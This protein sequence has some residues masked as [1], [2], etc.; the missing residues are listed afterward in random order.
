MSW[1][2]VVGIVATIVVGLPAAVRLT[3][4]R[5][6]RRIRF[7]PPRVEVASEPPAN[8][9]ELL[10]LFDRW[11]A[12]F[13]S[14]GFVV[15]AWLQMEDPGYVGLPPLHALALVRLER[16]DIWVVLKQADVPVACRPAQ[17]EVHSQRS[18]GT[19][20]LTTPG[21]G[22]GFFPACPDHLELRDAL[23]DGSHQL[24]QVHE[25]ALKDSGQVF[26]A[27][28]FAAAL[29][30]RGERDLTA[31]IESGVLHRT[32]ETDR[33]R[34]NFLAAWR[35]AKRL[36][37][38]AVHFWQHAKAKWSDAPAPPIKTQLVALQR[39]DVVF[40]P[41]PETVPTL[42]A[43]LLTGI[44]ALISFALIW[45]WQ[46]AGAIGIALLVHELGHLLA[47]R[48]FGYRDLQVFF[49][50]FMGG[51]TTG[52]KRGVS[53]PQEMLVLLAGPLPGLILGLVLLAMAADGS[54]F[55]NV[56]AA[57]LIALNLVNLLPL[58]PLDGGRIIHLLLARRSRFIETALRLVAIAC[59]AVGGFL[60]GDPLLLVL[61]FAVAAGL[62]TGFRLQRLAASAR[63]IDIPEA[64]CGADEASYRALAAVRQE[65]KAQDAPAVIA[66]TLKLRNRIETKPTTSGFVALG[67]ALYILSLTGGLVA[68]VLALMA[69]IQ[70]AE[71]PSDRLLATAELTPLDCH[72]AAAV[73][74]PAT[75]YEC[76]LRSNDEAVAIDA[77]LV[78]HSSAGRR[79]CGRRRWGEPQPS[80]QELNARRTL[81]ELEAGYADAIAEAYDSLPAR[82]GCQLPPPIDRATTATRVSEQLSAEPWF[83]QE[84]SA[85][86]GRVGDWFPESTQDEPEAVSAL[87]T[88][89]GCLEP[90][91]ER[92]LDEPD[93]AD[94]M[95]AP[96][97][98]NIVETWREGSRLRLHVIGDQGRTVAAH[99]CARG[100]EVSRATSPLA[101]ALKNAQRRRAESGD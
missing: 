63:E 91:P 16:P 55:S 75:L 90:E 79:F 24:V 18:D 15:V 10:S 94:Q 26:D 11:L 33:Y 41:Q 36:Q 78:V 44:A 35:W 53:A 22:S 2:L 5:A 89:L 84:V 42:I 20:L 17:I 59:F 68:T 73:D 28:S 48:V 100:C 65:A 9:D 40:Q 50:P 4:V 1:S 83:D 52:S 13:Q 19:W 8:A 29:Q 99:L 49:L 34:V 39:Y 54:S 27:I 32:S 61:S 92:D 37:T 43:F 38:A 67:L 62:A 69:S 30:R 57:A 7:S 77:E 96:L 80:P 51:A 97:E 46:W 66:Q 21:D 23:V 72:Q 101:H 81:S 74:S 58:W 31:L 60:F 82:L 85:L 3:Q 70:H 45:D 64:F 25:H 56:L 6:L 12:Q 86:Y 47:M 87:T 76:T 88:R 71:S 98:L 93:L 14:A 95:E